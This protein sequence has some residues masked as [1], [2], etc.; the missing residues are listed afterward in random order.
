MADQ[1]AKA[2]IAVFGDLAIPAPFRIKHECGCESDYRP[3]AAGWRLH[4]YEPEGG[5]LGQLTGFCWA[6]VLEAE[7]DKPVAHRPVRQVE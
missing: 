7:A 3:D 4:T 5:C 6:M 2:T 1:D